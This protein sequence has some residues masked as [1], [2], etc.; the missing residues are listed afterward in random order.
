MKC[1]IVCREEPSKWVD[2]YL[3]DV[4]P[5]LLNVLGK[6][7][8]EYNLDLCQIA[9]VEQVRISSDM[10]VGEIEKVCE[11]GSRWGLSLSYCM[12]LPE[13]NLEKI[14][15]KNASFCKG[16]DLLV[17][18][19]FFFVEYCK[20]SLSLSKLT[21]SGE[22][23]QLRCAGGE[24]M[25]LPQRCVEAREW[26]EIYESV[27]GLELRELESIGDYYNLTF[28]ILRNH[29]DDY[30]VPGY[31]GEADVFVGRNVELPKNVQIEKPV[32]IGDNVNL[33]GDVCIGPNVVVESNVVIDSGT[34]V[35]NSI[36]AGNS[37]LGSELEIDGKIVSKNNLIEPSCGVL[38]HLD[39]NYL[40]SEINGDVVFS[41][42]Q[43]VVHYALAA[44][45]AIVQLVPY[46]L[47]VGFSSK[48]PE[49]SG[50]INGVFRRLSLDKFPLVCATLG[51]KSYL[52]GHN[53]TCEFPP[54]WRRKKEMP[55]FNQG[56]FCYSDTSGKELEYEQVW[57][58]DLYYC[59]NMSLWLD[60]KIVLKTLL[61]RLVFIGG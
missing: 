53:I 2:E 43:K 55:F 58:D 30:V 15:A 27:D 8:V 49:A 39:E 61:K 45:I 5:Y 25:F 56:A 28:D 12:N 47:L 48:N 6:P 26:G 18:D 40:A 35:Q 14:I 33:K 57:L 29:S 59:G 4:W 50:F 41:L 60:V 10:G 7:L 51:G 11:N 31:S 1:L 9:G 23:A 46:L 34:V 24:L 44:C 38:L 20:N 13:D 17:L 54:S 16:D 21:Q 22:P 32:F 37:Y 42:S 3:P 19:G 52:V 36:I